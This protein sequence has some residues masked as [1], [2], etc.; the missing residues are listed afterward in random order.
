MQVRLQKFLADAGVASRR[1]CEEYILNGRVFVNGHPVRM[2]GS[3]VDPSADKVVVDG[4]LIRTRK[5]F[6]VVLHK[7]RGFVCTRSDE[8]GRRKVMDLLP[9]E[10]AHIYP[11]GR[12]DKE[13]EGLLLLTNDGDFSLRMTHPRYQVTK[14]YIASVMGRVRPAHLERI[15][16]GIVDK[17][18]KLQ[19]Q[20]TRLLEAN[21]SH[22]LVELDL[23]EGK[24]REVRR[25][26]ESQELVIERLVRV[27]IG[28]IRLGELPSGKWRTLTDGEIKSLLAPS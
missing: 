8:L 19:A 23:T 5:K 21:N 18:E 2:L 26:F 3:K 15:R 12:L 4:H 1:A 9:K 25:L 6:Y 28:Q 22:S 10:W 14:K 20:A 11:V 7:P 16:N 27:Q 17:G 13:T 24:N